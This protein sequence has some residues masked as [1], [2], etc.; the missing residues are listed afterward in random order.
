MRRMRADGGA[1]SVSTRLRSLIRRDIEA[2][3]GWLPFERF[4]HLALYAPDLGYYAR[5]DRLPIGAD[6]VTAP[7]L[8]PLFGRA[9]ARQ[10]AQLLDATGTR[11]LWEF[12]A[13][14][15]ALA[16]QLLDAL[17]DTVERCSIVEVSGALAARQRHTLA[18]FGDRVRWCTELPAVIDGVVVGNEVLDA[19]PVRLVACDGTRWRE[20]GV[21]ARGDAFGW[22]DRDAADAAPPLNA[23]AFAAGSVTELHRNATA[24]VATLAQRLRRGAVLLVDY[25]FPAHEYYHPQRA[26]GTLMC[27]RG[28][29][30]DT[31]PL[32]DVGDKD[33]SAHVDWSALA[34]AAQDAGA[35]VIGYASQAQVLLNCGITELLHGADLRTLAGAQKLVNEHEMGELF[36]V[37]AFARGLPAGVVPLG[38]ARG[39]RTHRL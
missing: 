2:A 9:L 32:T 28:H 7:E 12:G 11:E 16:A 36:K 1:D 18:R 31:D 29:L 8:S 10:V 17:G 34:L 6:F 21:V 30:A 20:R 4:M 26:G 14:T 35:E 38:F 39:D 3:G 15:G 25:G 13:G 23:D 27:H 19:M 5:T 22:H 33:I 24:F 37:L